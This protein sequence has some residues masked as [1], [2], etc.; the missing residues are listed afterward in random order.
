MLPGSRLAETA[1][2]HPGDSLEDI[3]EKLEQFRFQL[4]D[5]AIEARYPEGQT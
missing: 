4:V 3:D 2:L 5:G 1:N